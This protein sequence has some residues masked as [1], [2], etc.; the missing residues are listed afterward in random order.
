MHG[1]IVT[2]R[3]HVT[4][5]WEL[6]A[7]LVRQPLRP[8][9]QRMASRFQQLNAIRVTETA[10]E[11]NRRKSRGVQNFIGVSVTDAGENMRIGQRAF[12]C[13]IALPQAARKI[14]VINRKQFRA[15]GVVPRE[16]CLA[17]LQMQ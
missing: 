4:R 17:L 16:R 11:L 6:A 7:E 13:A 9:R 3:G 2:E 5:T 10:R 1:E 12:Q 8:N 15:A 14:T